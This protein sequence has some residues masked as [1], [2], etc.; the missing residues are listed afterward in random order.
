[1]Y[2]IARVVSEY[3]PISEL[4]IRTLDALDIDWNDLKDMFDHSGRDPEFVN[5]YD[6][7]STKATL[8]A[9]LVDGE[10]NL[11]RFL[12]QLDIEQLD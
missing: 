3:Y 10:I 2:R 9:E 8:I 5:I 11:D 1:M 4:L 12:Y 7:N 6:I